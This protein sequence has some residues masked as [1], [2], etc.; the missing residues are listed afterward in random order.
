[1]RFVCN[2]CN[3]IIHSEI[4]SIT[5]DCSKPLKY[6]VIIYTVLDDSQ[7]SFYVT[8]RSY[9]FTLYVPYLATNCATKN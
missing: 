1:M 9:L 8:Y 2:Q 7:H 3:K 4:T 6:F 5:I